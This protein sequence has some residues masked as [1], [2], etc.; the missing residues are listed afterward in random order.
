MIRFR[1]DIAGE[2]QLDRGI[3][4]FADGVT[5]YRPIWGV[6]EDDFYAEEKEQFRTEGEAGGGRWQPLS[7]AC[8]GWKAVHYPNTRI[9][10]R[11]GALEQSLTRAS[12]SNAVKIERR[13]ELILG[14][15]VPYAIYHQSIEPRT[16]LPRRPVIQVTESFKRG[17]MRHIHTYLVSM[18]TECGF[19]QGFTPGTLESLWA[20]TKR[21]KGA[22]AFH[23]VAVLQRL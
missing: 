10:E 12:D 2:V 19:R 22:S 4:R 15:S 5:D 20:T 3:A 16:R 13:K 6:I 8:A 1:M 21:G 18:A 14:T 9:L 17:V 7:E 11:T 23:G